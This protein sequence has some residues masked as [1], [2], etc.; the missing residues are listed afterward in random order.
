MGLQPLN[1]KPGP[2]PADL[3]RRISLLLAVT[4]LALVV[5]L[6][7]AAEK[8]TTETCPRGYDFGPWTFEQGLAYK[9]SVYGGPIPGYSLAGY[10]ATFAATDKNGDGKV[11]FKDVPDTPGLPMYLTHHT[12]NVSMSH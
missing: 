10:T 9:A 8:P 11:C 1:R 4:L 12:D 3:W 5:A 6:P 2:S 7:A